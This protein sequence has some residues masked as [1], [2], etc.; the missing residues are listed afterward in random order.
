[1]IEEVEHYYE[2]FK[3]NHMTREEARKVYAEGRK[4]N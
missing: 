3:N 4:I 1:M 2:E